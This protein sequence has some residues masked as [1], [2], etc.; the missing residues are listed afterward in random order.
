MRQSASGGDFRGSRPAHPPCTF[1]DP[2]S[3]SGLDVL[4]IAGASSRLRG[5]K[6]HTGAL[7]ARG[8]KCFT[9]RAARGRHPSGHGF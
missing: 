4:G 5:A 6:R 1:V 3:R 9:A 8:V 7:R 2:M